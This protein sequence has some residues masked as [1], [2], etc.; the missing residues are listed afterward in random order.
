MNALK[1]LMANLTEYHGGPVTT[2]YLLT[3]NI[4]RALI[5]RHIDGVVVECKYREMVGPFAALRPG[6]DFAERARIS[7]LPA[8]L[9]RG[10]ILASGL[11]ASDCNVGE[12]VLRLFETR[13]KIRPLW[14][15]TYSRCRKW[16]LA[17]PESGL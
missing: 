4:A 9:Y 12:A 8:G 13:T 6:P 10:E 16:K 5:A 7:P 1:N 15:A 3:G 11:S 14:C 17:K 2:E